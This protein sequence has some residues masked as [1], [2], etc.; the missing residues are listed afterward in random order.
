MSVFADDLLEKALLL[1]QTSSRSRTRIARTMQAGYLLTG[2]VLS[3]RPL[4]LHTSSAVQNAMHGRVIHIKFAAI[5]LPGSLEWIYD[6]G[7]GDR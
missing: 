1:F 2:G 4:H 5:A 3:T 7:V 6:S